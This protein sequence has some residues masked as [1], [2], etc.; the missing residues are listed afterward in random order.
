MGAQ[1][2]S[3]TTTRQSGKR[4][5]RGRAAILAGLT[6]ALVALPAGTAAAAPGG[7][8]PPPG[9]TGSPGQAVGAA[10]DLPL[11]GGASRT[12]QDACQD[13]NGWQ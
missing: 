11:T 3:S 13:V 1:T 2:T 5:G 8:I 6:A 7:T 12:W 9:A 10:C 4:V